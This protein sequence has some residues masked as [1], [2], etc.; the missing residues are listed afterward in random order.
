ME[1][2]KDFLS[3]TLKMAEGYNSQAIRIGFF[4]QAFGAVSYYCWANWETNPEAEKLAME[5]WNN[6][7][8]EKFNELIKNAEL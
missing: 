1:H 7:Y 6:E 4:H 2:L 8:S 5:L 3:S